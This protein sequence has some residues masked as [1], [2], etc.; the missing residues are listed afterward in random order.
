MN[1]SGPQ[2]EHR[3]R[4]QI[5]RPKVD[6]MAAR[7]TGDHTDDVEIRANR[8]VPHHA[9][10]NIR[11]AP[12]LDRTARSSGCVADAEYVLTCFDHDWS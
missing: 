10:E 4:G 12:Q 2:P 9:P 1:L 3:A 11:E 8:P 6:G 5:V 7:A